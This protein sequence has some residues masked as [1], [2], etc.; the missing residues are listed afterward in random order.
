MI[1]INQKIILTLIVLVGF[2]LRIIFI[3]SS[4][5]SLYGDELTIA[6]D[7]YSLLKTGHDELGNFLPLT[8]PMGAGR[9]AGYVY[10]SIPFI[11][12]FGPTA[13]GIRMLSILSGVGIIILMFF[14]VKKLFSLRVGIL[15]ASI[16]AVSPWDISLSRAGFEAHFALFLAL[17]GT[18]LFLKAQQKPILYVLSFL[19]FGITLHTYPT[20]K[21]SLLLFLPLLFWFTH[22]KQNSLKNR[23]FLIGVFIFLILGFSALTQTFIGGSETRF[24]DINVFSQPKLKNE[25]EQKIDYERQITSL[26]QS[27]AKQFH[28]RP[29]EYVKVLLENYLQNFSMDFLILHGDRNPRQNM[30]TMG[31]I[32]FED[33]ILI[34]IGILSFWS[35]NKRTLIFLVSWIILSPVPTAI[36][37]LPHALR[38][39]FM[40]LPILLLSAL[41]LNTLVNQKKKIA[42]YLIATIFIIQFSFFIQKLYFL[43]PREY[44][45]FWA[46]PAKLASKIVLENKAKYNYVIVSD[47]I[48]SIEFAY[49]VYAELNPEKVIQQNITKEKLAD[50]DFKKFDNV[51]IGT[52][53]SNQIFKLTS[54]LKGTVL[55]LTVA[56]DIGEFKDK[57]Y[58]ILQSLNGKDAILLYKQ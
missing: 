42:L 51:Y 55:Y 54:N 1:K 20:Y 22:L 28:N 50:F 25:I 31:E 2:I 44:S 24:S 21:L 4:P 46:Y 33:L 38:S 16:V 40:L 9:P 26:P 19:S 17:L 47:K 10:G 23:K 34:L 27:I 5:P 43:A 13:M 57:D 6:L 45:N 41:G 14:L 32:Y 12:I 49:P 37:D 36:I 53:E 48:D 3:S 7:S 35:K 11:A 56:T 58:Q 18:Y 15:A 39:A 29:V 30:A 52:L 8:F